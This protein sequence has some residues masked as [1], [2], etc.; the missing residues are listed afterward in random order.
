MNKGEVLVNSV[1]YALIIIG[2]FKHYK[3]VNRWEKLAK[4]LEKQLEEYDK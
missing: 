3:T 1:I 4:Q 2:I